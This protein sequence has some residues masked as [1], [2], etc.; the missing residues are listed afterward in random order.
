MNTKTIKKVIRKKFNEWVST[1]DCEETRKLVEKN[2]ILTGG[3]IASMLLKEQV[4]DFDVYFRNKE[5][6]KA[7]ADYYVNKFKMKDEQGHLIKVQDTNEDSKTEGRIKIFVKS[8]GVSAE[9]NTILEQPF[10]DVYDVISDADEV[11]EELLEE[12]GEKYRPIFLSPNA[13]TL[14]NKIQCVIRFYGEPE[15]IHKTYDFVH[16]TNYWTSWDNQV[17]TNNKALESL[18]SK[19]LYYC[20]S[21]YPL[22][23]VIRTRKFIKRGWHINAGQYLKMMYQLSQL[24]LNDFEVLEDQLIGVDSAYFMDFVEALKRKQEKEPDWNLDNT[25]LCSVIDKIF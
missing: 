25:Y 12:K 15:D 1:I 6:A 18:L 8:Q 3:A 23:S 19:H 24:D 20:G 11:S 7:V 9:D 21:E 14:A 13:I 4:K 5:T 2:T 16:A 10:E 17:V 22:C